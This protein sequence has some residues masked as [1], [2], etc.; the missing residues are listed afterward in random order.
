M[1]GANISHHH[2]NV[3]MERPQQ[4]GSRPA[5]TGPVPVRVK[6]VSMES[7]PYAVVDRASVKITCNDWCAA[8]H[9]S[10]KGHF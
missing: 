8:N 9:P 10:G 1:C 7:Q 4:C 5:K 2:K 6:T 3:L